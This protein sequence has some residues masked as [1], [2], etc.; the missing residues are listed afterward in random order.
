MAIFSIKKGLDIRIAGKPVDTVTEAPTPAFLAL[1]PGDFLGIKPKLMVAEGDKVKVGQPL[2]YAKK[3]PDL[4]FCA[5]A[6]GTVREIRRGA[7]RALTEV[8]IERDAQEE[9]VEYPVYTA[10]RVGNLAPEKITSH[11]LE[12]GMWPVIRQRPFAKIPLSTQQPMAIYVNGMDT[13]PLACDPNVAIN[14]RDADFQLGI[15]ILSRLTKGKTYLTLKADHP[16]ASAFQNVRNAETH[17]FKGPH[18]AGLVGTHIRRIEPLRRN[19]VIWYLRAVDV[20]DIGA[21]FRTGK[22][23]VER[24]VAV[25][26]DGIQ[27]PAYLKIRKGAQLS[28]FLE[29]RLG[30]GKMRYISG[31]ILTG[32]ATDYKGYFG[33][34]DTTCT[35]LPESDQRDFMGWAMPG[36]KKY[37][38]FR[39]FG[40]SLIPRKV[41]HL[42]T[43]KNGGV[44]PIVN[45]GAWEKM[46]ALD[47][48]ISYLVRAILANDFEEAEKLGLLELSEEDVALCTFA[49]PSKME[50]G[51]IIRQGLDLFEKE[52]L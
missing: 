23:P 46:L 21:F 47:I 4:K 15:D 12:S 2:L 20:A 50:L 40:S 16:V 17:Y 19:E 25:S 36:W 37:S 39:A 43:R 35:V 10:D 5:P 51:P 7:R 29:G 44:R 27:Q 1:K 52:S 3:F 22:F 42:D 28:S 45:V 11:L 33:F 24:I 41:Y 49:C 34:Y 32:T 26:G 31:T 9:W 30:S 48:H 14:G 18:P 8:I 6:G 38:T 13:E